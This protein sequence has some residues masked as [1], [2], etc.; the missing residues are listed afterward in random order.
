MVLLPPYLALVVF[1]AIGLE[2]RYGV[3]SCVIVATLRLFCP[4]AL[5]LVLLEYPIPGPLTF[6]KLL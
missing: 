4:P 6:S 2:D 5:P 3:N 1:L